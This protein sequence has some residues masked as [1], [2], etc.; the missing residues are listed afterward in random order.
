MF[1]YFILKIHLK[2][3]NDLSTVGTFLKPVQILFTQILT[4]WESESL[5][6]E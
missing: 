2:K 6:D 5:I 1:S 3:R 4:C